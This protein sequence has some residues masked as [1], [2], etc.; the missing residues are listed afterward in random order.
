MEVESEEFLKTG[1]SSSSQDGGGGAS[2]PCC[3]LG[4]QGL[5]LG[6]QLP[7]HYSGVACLVRVHNLEWR[8]ALSEDAG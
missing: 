4:G 1:R 6:R 2:F 3:Q 7:L 5:G 8:V